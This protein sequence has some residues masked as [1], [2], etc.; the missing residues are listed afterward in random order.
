MGRADLAH[1]IL[2]LGSVLQLEPPYS[3]A[4]SMLGDETHVANRHLVA[5]V[6]WFNRQ[7][8]VRSLAVIGRVVAKFNTGGRYIEEHLAEDFD[9]PPLQ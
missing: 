5:F 6:G 1:G 2:D 4:A 3:G 9:I 8:H 7:N